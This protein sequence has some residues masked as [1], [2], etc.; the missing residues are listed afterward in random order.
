MEVILLERV[1]NLGT[2]GDIVNV[3]NGYGRNFLVPQGMAVLATEGNKKLFEEKKT[4]IESKNKQKLLD[5]ENIAQKLDNLFVTI[6]CQASEDGR[7]FGSV[8]SK[9]V[10]DNIESLLDGVSISKNSIH[11]SATIKYIG[12]YKFDLMLH[13]DVVVKGLL[14]VARSNTEAKEAKDT[15]FSSPTP[16]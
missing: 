2:I 3:K 6:I 7:L 13:P 12:I 8:T 4:D 9:D 11:F 1:K 14:N 5:A 10:A 15:Y 16:Q